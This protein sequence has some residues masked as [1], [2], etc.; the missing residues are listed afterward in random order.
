[1]YRVDLLESKWN[2]TSLG[3]ESFQALLAHAAATKAAVESPAMAVYVSDQASREEYEAASPLVPG[4]MVILLRDLVVGV[5]DG[6]A[7]TLLCRR[8][9]APNAAGASDKESGITDTQRR[10]SAALA[11]D[12]LL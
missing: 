11:R 5:V 7:T 2:E 1:M 9:I 4:K 12:Q 3:N 10:Q 8:T 6:N